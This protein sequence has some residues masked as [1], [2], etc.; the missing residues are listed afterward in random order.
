MP[1]RSPTRQLTSYFGRPEDGLNAGAAQVVV[2]A[3]ESV[4][5]VGLFDKNGDLNR[6]FA[7]AFVD[8]FGLAQVVFQAPTKVS[9]F[10]LLDHLGRDVQLANVR[11]EELLHVEIYRRSLHSDAFGKQNLRPPNP[12]ATVRAS[13]DMSAVRTKHGDSSESLAG[14]SI[15]DRATWKSCPKSRTG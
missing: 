2:E 8:A 14:A 11:L 9:Q 13:N 15:E 3:R 6:A 12:R 10:A 7:E 1:A 4:A 5:G